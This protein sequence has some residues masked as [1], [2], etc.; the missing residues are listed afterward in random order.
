LVEQ[1]EELHAPIK[2]YFYQGWGIP[3]QRIDS[4]I[5]ARVMLSC[6]RFGMPNSSGVNEKFVALP[7]HD[8]FIVEANHKDQLL[9]AMKISLS[10]VLLEEGI[11]G[12]RP[13][14]QYEP[15]FDISDPVDPQRLDSD[16]LY[17]RREE[18]FLRGS[19]IPEV[20][21]FRKTNKDET[22]DLFKLDTEFNR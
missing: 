16:Y 3:L 17:A 21:Y 18:H 13:M 20:H 19:V 1:F 7:V 2:D 6:M 22:I 12:D 14:E 4:D 8:S 11:L 10:E 5:A 15:R 9:Q